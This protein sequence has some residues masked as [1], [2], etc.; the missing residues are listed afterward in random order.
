M[1]IRQTTA[2][3]MHLRGVLALAIRDQLGH[4]SVKTT[5]SFYI[6]SD[7]EYQRKQNEKLIS[8]VG[9]KWETPCLKNPTLLQALEI[10]GAPGVTRTRGTRIRNPLLY[11]PE[12]QGH[13]KYL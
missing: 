12:L 2:S 4:T 9:R 10:T 11:P 6:G 1:E 5:E 7:I 8:I 13:W 3:F